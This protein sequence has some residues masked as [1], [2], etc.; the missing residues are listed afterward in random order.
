MDDGLPSSTLKTM[1]ANKGG[2][3]LALY[4]VSEPTIFKMLVCL[5]KISFDILD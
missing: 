3:A 5:S 2:K 1:P 4:T